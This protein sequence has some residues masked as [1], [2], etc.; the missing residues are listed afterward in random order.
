MKKIRFNPELK[1]SLKDLREK[2]GPSVSDENMVEVVAGGC[3]GVCKIT[4]SW[5]CR[6]D[7]VTEEMEIEEPSG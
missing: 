1:G 7:I 5:Y 6:E 2:L 4:C 3:G